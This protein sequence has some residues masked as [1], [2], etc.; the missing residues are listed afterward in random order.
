MAENA[1]VRFSPRTT[2]WLVAFAVCLFLSV[3]TKSW[4]TVIGC[5]LCG[6]MVGASVRSRGRTPTIP[7]PR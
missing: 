3:W 4:L 2:M 5:A 7:L 1:S 6:S